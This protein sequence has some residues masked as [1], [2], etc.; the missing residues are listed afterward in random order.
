MTLT[1]CCNLPCPHGLQAGAATWLAP[2]AMSTRPTNKCAG[3][4]SSG[5]QVPGSAPV[6]M[7]NSEPS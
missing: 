6:V 3:H 7:R 2:E 5:E 4:H 1:V